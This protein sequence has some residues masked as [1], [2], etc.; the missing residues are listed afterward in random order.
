MQ[1]RAGSFS[2]EEIEEKQ[3]PK[4]LDQVVPE[5]YSPIS[6]VKEPEKKNERS[7]EDLIVSQK[8]QKIS[9]K[10][11]RSDPEYYKKYRVFYEMISKQQKAELG[12]NGTYDNEKQ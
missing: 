4:K 7:G 5:K 2:G 6:A 3:I 12:E 11:P 9:P 10:M 1:N 8:Q